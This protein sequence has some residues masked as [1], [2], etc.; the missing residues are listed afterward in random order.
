[1]TQLKSVSPTSSAHE[2]F[3]TEFLHIFLGFCHKK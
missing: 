1:V 3:F 2:F